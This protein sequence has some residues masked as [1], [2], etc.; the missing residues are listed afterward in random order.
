[1][2]RDLGPVLVAV[3]LLVV[4]IGVLAWTGGLS[5]F[6]RLPGDVRIERDHLRLYIPWV[7]MLLVSIVLSLLISIFRR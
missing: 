2:G 6:G 1:M 3:G 7:S 5:W 4:V